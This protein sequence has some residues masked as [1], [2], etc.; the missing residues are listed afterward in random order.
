MCS[1]V[2]NPRRAAEESLERTDPAEFRKLKEEA[3][4]IGAGDPAPAVVTFTTEMACVAV[5]ELIDALTGFRGVA[6][7]ISH[8]LRRFHLNDDRQLVSKRAERC[9]ICVETTCWG[10]GDTDPFLGIIG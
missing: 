1:G 7:M 10:R 3:Y 9:P 4:V 2:I 5:N 8:R 6:G